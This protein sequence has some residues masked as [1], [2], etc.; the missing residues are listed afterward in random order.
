MA[1]SI[2]AAA[3]VFSCMI[4]SAWAQNA[5]V[6]P[7]DMAALQTAT[8]QQR[9]M[10]AALTCDTADLYNSFVRA[11][12]GD[13]QKSDAALRAYFVRRDAVTGVADYN[14]FKTKLANLY[15]AWSDG[16]RKTYCR[17]A[18]ASLQAALKD[19]KSLA[20][21]VSTQPI[22]DDSYTSCGDAVAGGAMVARGTADAST[23]PAKAAQAVAPS[24]APAIGAAGN[25]A[26]DNISPAPNAA[27]PAGDSPQRVRSP[28]YDNRFPRQGANDQRAYNNSG[29]GY[30]DA[31]APTPYYGYAAPDPY[32]RSP[33]PYG[34]Y[35]QPQY[36]YRGYYGPVYRAG[37]P[38]PRFFR[39]PGRR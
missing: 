25:P 37:V 12:R 20:D 1:K 30:Y 4:S 29:G 7:Q 33:Y 3:L 23:L 18:T 34:W 5:C 31:P 8:V 36:Y 9:F 15:S 14:A 32:A 24:A 11:Y 28:S 19:K 21:L 27:K 2:R 16:N 39:Y 17:N 13:L 6:R 26:A 10:V 38:P 35:G 22:S